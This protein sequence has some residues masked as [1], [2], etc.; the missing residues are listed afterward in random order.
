MF[1]DRSRIRIEEAQDGVIP[2]RHDE[3]RNGEW[4]E[5]G[6][7]AIPSHCAGDVAAAFAVRYDD[8]LLKKMRDA[9]GK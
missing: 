1:G 9:K 7:Y 4:C 2:V 3:L 5:I 6:A 8:H